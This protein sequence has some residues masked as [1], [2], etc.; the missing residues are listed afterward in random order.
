MLSATPAATPASM[1]DVLV[2]F[3]VLRSLGSFDLIVSNVRNRTP[4]FEAF[5]MQNAPAPA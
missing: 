3:P 1:L 5:E 4:D 2:G